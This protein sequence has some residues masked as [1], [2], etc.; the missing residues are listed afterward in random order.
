MMK[1]NAFLVGIFLL[2]ALALVVAGALTLNQSGLFTK[3]NQAMVYFDNSVKG[4]YVGAPVTFRGVKM[5]EVTR[6]DVEVDPKTLEILIPVT[7]TLMGDTFLVISGQQASQQL[8]LKDAVQRGLRARLIMQSIVTGQTAVEL[9]FR[10]DTPGRLHA[11][12]HS[13]LPEIPTRQ[14]KLDALISQVKD[15][16]LADLVADLRR[17]MATLD[18]TLKASQV[19]IHS[20]SQ[21]F[22][23]TSVQARQSLVQARQTLE[24]ASQTLVQASAALDQVK[25][26]ANSTL[27]SIQQLS[28]TT[29]GTVIEA[30][31][32]LL[33]TLQETRRAAESAQRAMNELAEAT[34]PGAPL[35]ADIESTVS[36]LSQAARSLRSFAD[37]LEREPSSLIFGG[38]NP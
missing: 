20:S 4:L 17:T 29:R 38:N 36:D 27:L 7:L 13:P 37:Q 9:D 35:R 21:H 5:G 33:Q 22:D 31:P 11:R 18:E 12:A 26:Q 23:A 30:Q 2:L 32:A 1:R 24:Q 14:D 34:A 28:D 10:P 16:P 25:T 15:L 8:D 19:A 6:I 3:R